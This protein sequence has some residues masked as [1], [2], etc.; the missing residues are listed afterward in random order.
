MREGSAGHKGD[1]GSPIFLLMPAQARLDSPSPATLPQA[2]Q[3]S[4][5]ASLSFYPR[6][7]L[8]LCLDVGSTSLLSK[9]GLGISQMPCVFL[10]QPK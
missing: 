5:V 9:C 6:R 2:S 7:R 10:M 1:P 4:L 3:R 8:S